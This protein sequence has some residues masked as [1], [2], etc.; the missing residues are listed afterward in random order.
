VRYASKPRVYLIGRSQEAADK[1]IAEFKT[2]NSGSQVEFIKSDAALLKSVDDAV[3]QIKAKE[4]KINLLSLSAGIFT[5]QGRNETAEG[6]DTKLSLHYYSRMRFTQGFL[7]LLAKAAAEPAEGGKVP[8]ARVISVLGAGHESNINLDDIDLKHNY[9]LQNAAYHAQTANTLAPLTLW[10]KEPLTKGVTFIHSA[11]GGV[12]T[13]L[14]S[15]PG[16]AK[17]ALKALFPIAKVLA[18]SQMNSPVECGE[19]HVWAGTAEA[20]GKGGVVLLNPKSEVIESEAVRKMV[21]DGVGEK[22]WEHTLEVFKKI[23]ETGKY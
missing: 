19:R 1:L 9:S 20:F 12:Q 5:F 4:S 2:L 22:I 3:A 17:Y 15:R 16:L 23:D 8:L 13:S 6:L 18:P 7:P 14:A 10:E 21:K 11:P